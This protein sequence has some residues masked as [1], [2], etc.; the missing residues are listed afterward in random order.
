MGSNWQPS[1]SRQGGD[2]RNP[3]ASLRGSELQSPCPPLDCPTSTDQE[4]TQCIILRSRQ[5]ANIKLNCS[6][7]TFLYFLS[8]PASQK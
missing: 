7:C 5:D 2:S 6:V 3:P 8:V 4:K 1:D